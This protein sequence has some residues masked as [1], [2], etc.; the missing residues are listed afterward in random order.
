MFLSLPLGAIVQLIGVA[1]VLSIIAPHSANFAGYVIHSVHC[2]WAETLFK[3]NDSHTASE[4]LP[5]YVLLVIK[6]TIPFATGNTHT[7]K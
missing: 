3:K 5:D 2:V 7:F 1:F 6:G 4:Q